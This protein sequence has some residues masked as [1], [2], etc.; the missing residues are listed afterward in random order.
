MI[1]TNFK[2]LLSCQEMI[3]VAV[4]LPKGT[5]TLSWFA[6][7]NA[8]WNIFCLVN[9]VEGPK[10]IMTW[11]HTCILFREKE[12][13]SQGR[14]Q[15]QDEEMQYNKN[16]CFANIYISGNAV[17]W[18]TG[19]MSFIRKRQEMHRKINMRPFRLNST[20]YFSLL[21]QSA[22]HL[23]RFWLCLEVRDLGKN[24]FC[25]MFVSLSST[26]VSRLSLLRTFISD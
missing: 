15:E 9:L 7:R 26:R 23:L 20:F 25:G 12:T 17:S 24:L 4:Q 14:K 1:E 22:L 10:C 11:E 8:L 18:T 13:G 5:L 6:P 16:N 3:S 19:L 21:F 2:R